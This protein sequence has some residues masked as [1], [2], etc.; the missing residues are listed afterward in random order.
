MI[1]T[2]S[3][4]PHFSCFG[5]LR[6]LNYQIGHYHYLKYCGALQA[7]EFPNLQASLK[8]AIAS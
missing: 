5:C 8:S 6:K 7:K 4:L 2:L 1:L 3:A